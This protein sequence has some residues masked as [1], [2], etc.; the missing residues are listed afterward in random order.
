M[1]SGLQ[2]AAAR[3]AAGVPHASQVTQPW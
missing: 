1:G 3:A 2:P